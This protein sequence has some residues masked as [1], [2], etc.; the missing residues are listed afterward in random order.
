[1][2]APKWSGRRAALAA[3]HAGKHALGWDDA[4]YRDVLEQL[5]GHR[6]AAD[7]AAQQ[8]AAVLDYMRQRGFGPTK[9]F[10]V[11]PA[12]QRQLRLVRALWRELA[13]LGVV[14]APGEPALNRFAK[15]MVHVDRLE[16]ATSEQL[17]KVTEA[18][19][20]MRARAG[21][22]IHLDDARPEE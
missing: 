9:Q 5:T 16:W 10:T 19:K 15:R 22:T 13:R 3:I 8:L 2:S 17:T 11:T 18:L 14:R 6:S 7:C 20:A 21:K 4:T 1:M 12:R